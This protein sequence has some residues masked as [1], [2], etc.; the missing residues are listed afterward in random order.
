ML[1]FRNHPFLLEIVLFVVTVL[2]S[3]FCPH[4]SSKEFCFPWVIAFA[5]YMLLAQ[6]RDQAI[7][8]EL[9]RL[10]YEPPDNAYDAVHGFCLDGCPRY[11][12]LH[13]VWPDYDP[14]AGSP[15]SQPNS[16][17]V[18]LWSTDSGMTLYPND[19]IS[20][21]GI[22]G[23]LPRQ[24]SSP[25]NEP[26][27]GVEQ[28]ENT[29]ENA[30]QQ[31]SPVNNAEQEDSRA[32]EEQCYLDRVRANEIRRVVQ[33]GGTWNPEARRRFLEEYQR[34][35]PRRVPTGIPV[36]TSGNLPIITLNMDGA[37]DT[38]ELFNAD[39]PE[40]QYDL[41]LKHSVW[42]LPVVAADAVDD[43][44]LWTDGRPRTSANYR[45]AMGS[46]RSRRAEALMARIR[47]RVT[48]RARTNEQ[49]ARLLHH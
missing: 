30:E 17:P 16:R 11:R 22:R 20:R 33:E 29:A 14:D 31:E 2:A 44:L 38:Y 39:Q 25:N 41:W 28:Q 24:A 37:T 10:S 43:Q 34:S 18:S 45:R 7:A 9:E 26:T 21:D 13:G 12:C 35:R 46:L 40:D 8:R 27:E 19:S 23:W 3:T 4:E 15:T 47:G 48:S 49:N 1:A 36:Q 5:I 32:A 6:Q 42:D